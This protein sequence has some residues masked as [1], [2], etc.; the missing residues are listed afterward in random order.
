MHVLHHLDRIA[1][2]LEATHPAEIPFQD[3]SDELQLLF[4]ELLMVGKSASA[5]EPL[6]CEVIWSRLVASAER[7]LEL[8][9]SARYLSD[10]LE[11]R[12][13]LK[14]ATMDLHF[15]ADYLCPSRQA[16]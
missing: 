15:I 1:L 9:V 2:D 14:Q 12:A 10:V 5:G 16:S 13:A 4:R 7:R 3:Y 8:V 11:R 6:R